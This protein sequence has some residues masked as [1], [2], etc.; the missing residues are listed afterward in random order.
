MVTTWLPHW[1]PV[2]RAKDF[3]NDFGRNGFQTRWSILIQASLLIIRNLLAS[4]IVV[5]IGSLI[6]I[7]FDI[8]WYVLPS[9]ACLLEFVIAISFEMLACKVYKRGKKGFQTRSWQRW[10]YILLL[11][12]QGKESNSFSWICLR[13]PWR[14]KEKR[15][16]RSRNGRG[17]THGTGLPFSR[18]LWEDMLRISKTR[19]SWNIRKAFL[20][21][22]QCHTVP[23]S[24]VLAGGCRR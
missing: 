16:S 6:G 1:K 8:L 21:N 18:K 14:H 5:P 12:A 15:T 9:N 3:R 23:L 11:E 20:A 4:G 13:L 10:K 17:E 24:V 22:V 19:N 7:W 2:L